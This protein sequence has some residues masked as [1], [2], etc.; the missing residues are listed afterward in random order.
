MDRTLEMLET[1]NVQRL[2]VTDAMIDWW[3]QQTQHAARPGPASTSTAQTSGSSGVEDV[4]KRG[5]SQ[6]SEHQWG[7]TLPGRGGT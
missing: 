1:G 5:D 2:H 3:A 6:V 4:T 7:E